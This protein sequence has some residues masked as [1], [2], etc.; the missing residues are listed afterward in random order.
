MSAFLPQYDSVVGCVEREVQLK[1][2]RLFYHYNFTHIPTVAMLG[3]LP[4]TDAFSFGWLKLVGERILQGAGNRSALDDSQERNAKRRL[5]CDEFLRDLNAGLV[6]VEQIRERV[7]ETLRF[8]GR[9]GAPRTHAKHLQDF[10]A[11]FRDIG[12]PPIAKDFQ[13][14]RVFAAQRVAG[15]NPVVITRLD[16][17]DD[18]LPLDGATFQRAL[19]VNLPGTTDTLD[20]ALAEGRLFLADYSILDGAEL[21]TLPNGQKYLYAPLA[22][23]VVSGPKR[24]LLPIAI[25]CRPTA[26]ADNPLFTPDDGWNWLIAKT[27]VETADG[28]L[29]EASTHLARTHLVMEAFVMATYRQLA[30]RHPLSVLLRPHF[31]GTLAI[32]DSAWK[33]LVADGGAVD[34]LL[35][36]TIETSRGLAAK[37][38]H[39]M[40]LMDE[41]LPLTFQ[42]RG[43]ADHDGIAEYPYRDDALL[44]WDAIHHWADQYVRIYYQTDMDV[45]EDYELQSW[46]REL[47]SGDGGRLRGL[48]NDGEVQTVTDLVEV[49]AFII[50]TC[51]AQHAAVNFPQYDCMSYVPNMPLAGYRPAPTSKSGGTEADYLAMLPTLDMA[52]LQ[53]E[54][55]YL[56]GSVHYTRL[57]DYG[58]K[59]FDDARV[60][61]PLETFQRRVA[62]IDS[63][64]QDRNRSRRPYLTLVPSGVPQSINI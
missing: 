58:P 32:N 12:L 38:L 37:S 53:M 51:S 24:E 47:R 55:T 57:G 6:K 60:A 42:R 28:N 16:H 29:H 7:I 27:I 1:G 50:Y 61:G 36:G 25:Q 18:R 46:G 48:P 10:A 31:E 20:A 52:E 41:R 22:V 59:H 63:I 17:R 21:G 44:Y 15:V 43:V 9:V 35:G 3:T 4:I 30:R 26:A 62:A 8:E 33:H 23:F 45:Q 2:E 13:D 39:S 14:D 49:V 34:R 56:L 64:I 11:M 54:V 19:A 40:N 5:L